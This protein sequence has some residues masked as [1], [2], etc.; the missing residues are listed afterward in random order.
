ME[1]DVKHKVND[2]FSQYPERKFSKGQ[3]LI[4]AGDDPTGIYYIQIGQ[5]RQYDINEKGDEVV[6]NVFEHPSFLPMPWLL[7]GTR[8]Q[9]FFEAFTPVTVRIAP[10]DDVLNF[11]KK[12]HDVTLDLLQ[13]LYRGVD[14]I[15]RRMTH[16]MGGSARS[17]VLFELVLECKRF[18]KK[19]KNGTY[20]LEMHEDELASRSGL[21]RE[22]I[23]RHLSK[24]NHGTFITVTHK[25]IIVKNLQRLEEE[26]GDTIAV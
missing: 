22:T 7:N 16:L 5:I 11:I 25:E 9:Y 15:Q 14:G 2:F 17:R 19:Q 4:Y 13:R 20:I 26:L 18:G 21:A 23:S 3:I 12:N 1:R 8:N 6:V 10:G 24:L